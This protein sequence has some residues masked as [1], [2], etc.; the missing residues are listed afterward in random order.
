MKKKIII[1][2]AGP[3]GLTAAY[4]VLKNSKKYDV[5]IY[6]K[7]NTV[8]GIS[9]TIEY[10]G[11]YM[12][13]GGHRFFS[14]IEEVNSIWK[15]LM[16]IQNKPS[17]DDKKLHREKKLPKEG[18]NP[19]KEDNVLLI[20][21][22]ISRI[23]FNKKLIAY[24]VSLN[25]DTIKKIG[26]FRSINCGLS[27]LKSCF[28]KKKEDNLAAFYINRF[29]KKL[30]E[31]F[32]KDYTKKL[33]GRSPKYLSADWGAQRVKGLSIKKVIKEYF[34]KITNK[35]YKTNE[36]SLIETFLYQKK[37]PGQMW[38][39]M[40]KEVEKLGGKI[41]Y[42][43]NINNIKIK[44]NKIIEIYNNNE[45]V[46]GNYIISSI[47]IKDLINII[48][49]APKSIV[50]ISNA[51]PYRDFITIGLILKNINLK[52]E[53]DYKTINNIA[54]D[55]WIYIQEKKYKLGRIQIF[56]NWSPYLVKDINN[57]VSLGLEYFC[58]KNDIFW[59][60]TDDEITKFAVKELESMG[61]IEKDNVLD[62]HVERVEKAYP[63]YFGS[64]EDIDK[65]QNYINSIDNLYCIGRN[66][67][68][69]YNNMDHSMMTAIE[70]IKC[71]F[72][73]S[74]KDDIW[75]VNTEKEYIEDEKTKK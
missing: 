19:E 26:F 64:Y 50:K 55:T 49:K 51:L 72:G 1:L 62:Y 74:S 71:I 13:L 56:N 46:K 37:G 10:N 48:E 75:K 27:Y 57:T 45:K 11:N 32:F 63:A 4:Y 29:G 47:P 59:C 53:T 34:S 21:R 67:Q 68:H 6:E 42:N 35:N 17:K 22:R 30:Y 18:K 66:G 69:R 61:I 52:N 31:I 8:G 7:S 23:Y 58:T 41:I 70:S 60:M 5:E 20:R 65:V 40:A 12:D 25:F 14:K 24:P 73:E 3:A 39:I 28:F 16:E 2:G 43:S 54:P 15:E 33:W 36:T 38:N 44:N 9:K